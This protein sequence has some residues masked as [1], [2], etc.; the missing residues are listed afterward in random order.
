LARCLGPGKT[1]FNTKQFA[2][3]KNLDHN[4]MFLKHNFVFPQVCSAKNRS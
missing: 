1:V 3:A 4:T 2:L